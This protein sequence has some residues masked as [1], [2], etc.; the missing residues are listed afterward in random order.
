MRL[1]ADLQPHVPRQL[2][3]LVDA[4]VEQVQVVGAHVRQRRREVADVVAELNAR[5]RALLR[6]VVHAVG[7]HGR[8]VEVE[9]RRRPTPARRGRRCRLRRLLADVRLQ[10]LADRRSRVVVRRWP[11]DERDAA[12]VLVGAAQLPAAERAR[13]TTPLQSLPQCSAAPE[14]QPA[15]PCRSRSGSAGRWARRDPRARRP[16]GSGSSACRAATSACTAP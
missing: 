2:E 9:A 11:H 13:P 4:D 7:L 8:V 15:A 10:A 3:V 5:V 1:D 12:L 16:A 14:R 6:R